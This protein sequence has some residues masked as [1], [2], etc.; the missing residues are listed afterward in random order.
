MDVF[1]F[2]ARFALALVGACALLEAFMALL[3]VLDLNP[4]GFAH[5]YYPLFLFI[6]SVVLV[7]WV[8]RFIPI[9]RFTRSTKNV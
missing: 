6:V 8:L 1:K 9:L 5:S 4:M 2:I 3:G 7:F